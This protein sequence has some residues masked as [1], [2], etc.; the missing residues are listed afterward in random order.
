M[1]RKSGT[2]KETGG[3]VSVTRMLPGQLVARLAEGTTEERQKGRF[4]VKQ[5]RVAPAGCQGNCRAIHEDGDAKRKVLA[6]VVCN[7]VG[8]FPGQEMVMC[9]AAVNV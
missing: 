8:I 5:M 6:V 3:V 7:K 2:K 4:L 1:T 9:R